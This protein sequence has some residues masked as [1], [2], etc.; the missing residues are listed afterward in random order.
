MTPEQA[1]QSENYAKVFT[2]STA[3]AAEPPTTTTTTTTTTK[4]YVGD[5]VRISVNKSLFT[6]GA[7]ASWSEE[8]FTIKR[9]RNTIPVVYELED[10]AGEV[11][12]GGFYNEQLQKTKQEIYRVEKIVRR[13]GDQVFVKWSGYPDKFNSW[14]P[15]N[16][17]L[18]SGHDTE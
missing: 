14:M 16:V 3:T 5:N 13:R 18:K 8:I 17:I 6:K 4:F 2:V 9:I 7:T 15:A 1:C 11:V 12:K 10:L